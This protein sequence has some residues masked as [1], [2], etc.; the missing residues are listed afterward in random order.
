MSFIQLVTKRYISKQMNKYL[1]LIHCS[2]TT[3]SLLILFSSTSGQWDGACGHKVEYGFFAYYRKGIENSP[4]PECITGFLVD[5]LA[6]TS[7]I[8]ILLF[9]QLGWGWKKYALSRK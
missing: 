4:N 6:V 5:G 8:S 7:L 1:F 9:L 2:F 3:L